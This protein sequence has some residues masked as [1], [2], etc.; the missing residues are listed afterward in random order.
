[1]PDEFDVD[2]YLSEIYQDEAFGE[3]LFARLAEQARDPQQVAC[4]RLLERLERVVKNR[5]A[6]E[7]ERRGRDTSVEPRRID[8]GH[9]YAAAL[10]GADW[11][12]QMFA[13]QEQIRI[14]T[15]DFRLA[16]ARAPVDAKSATEFVLAHEQALL[17]FFEHEVAGTSTGSRD[18][19]VA[20]L[21][22]HDPGGFC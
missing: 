7:L 2:A 9:R 18:P 3:A 17:H 15:E 19:I 12:E 10:A 4:W 6:R 13:F 14:Y 22:R 1:M 21:E 8:N 16:H 20:F 11:P 5:L